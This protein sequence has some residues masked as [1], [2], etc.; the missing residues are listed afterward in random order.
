MQIAAP[1]RDRMMTAIEQLNAVPVSAPQL[2]AALEVLAALPAH[3]Q[4]RPDAQALAL[5]A[6]AAEAGY[7]QDAASEA[8]HAR[9]TALARWTAMHDPERQSD[10][11]SVLDAAAR[12]PLGDTGSGIGFEAGGFQEL[13]LFID[14]LPW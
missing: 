13:I 2:E 1:A 3:L 12:F 11:R 5:Q 6:Y 8:L 4:S 10:A 7:Q 14:D 9:L